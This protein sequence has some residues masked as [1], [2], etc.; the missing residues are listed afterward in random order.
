VA[1]KSQDI[2]T[3]EINVPLTLKTV[4]NRQN[5][6]EGILI[7]EIDIE[8]VSGKSPES[9]LKSPLHPMSVRTAKF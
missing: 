3:A 9:P 7:R 1:K 5:T 6:H 4:P 2:S 8:D